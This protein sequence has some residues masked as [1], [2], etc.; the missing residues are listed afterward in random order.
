MPGADIAEVKRVVIDDNV[1]ADFGYASAGDLVLIAV[2]AVSLAGPVRIVRTLNG[3]EVNSAED[4]S[5]AYNNADVMDA[6]KALGKLEGLTRET[7]PVAIV[8]EIHAAKELTVIRSAVPYFH[9]NIAACADI[10]IDVLCAGL[11]EVDI[12]VCHDGSAIEIG[13]CAVLYH[14]C[15]HIGAVKLVR[16][17]KAVGVLIRRAQTFGCERDISHYLRV[18]CAIIYH[19]TYAEFAV[20]LCG[21]DCLFPVPFNRREIALYAV[22][23]YYAPPDVAVCAVLREE[24]HTQLA[25]GALRR[26]FV[27]IRYRNELARR[28][29][30][31]VFRFK[32]RELVFSDNA[33]AIGSSAVLGIQLQFSCGKSLGMYADGYFTRLQGA[34][35]HCQ[36]LSGEE[37]AVVVL[38]AVVIRG[39]AVIQSYKSASAGYF[40]F[41]AVARVSDLNAVL[42]SYGNFNERDV[43]AVRHEHIAVCTDNDCGGVARSSQLLP[44]YHAAVLRIA[45]CADNAWLKRNH[46]TRAH[47]LV[48]VKV[49]HMAAD[50]LSVEI[51]PDMMRVAVN[52]NVH[53]FAWHEI[54]V[55]RRDV[56]HVLLLRREPYALVEVVDILRETGCVNN[57]EI[58]VLGVVRGRLADIVKSRPDELTAAEF[59]VAV[60][61]PGLHRR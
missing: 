42:I 11:S 31:C 28:D 4:Y 1:V 41:H 51:Q 6:R 21:N 13:Y 30:V 24:L 45:L 27:D 47:F 29:F 23:A 43:P 36:E 53:L 26:K 22:S 56:K 9:G 17:D 49:H 52:Q 48:R 37:P 50:E 10:D 25:R 18:L 32:I 15:R 34:F 59:A 60:E 8:C 39:V 7:A 20:A 58:A 46:K 40:D 12:L 61:F 14:V 5:V 2:N 57:S 44:G 35:H 54:P 19:C 3:Y 33:D 55:G 38:V 16:I